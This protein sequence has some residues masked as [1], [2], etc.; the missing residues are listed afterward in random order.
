MSVA[1]V[2]VGQVV[3][4]W[5][6]EQVLSGTYARCRCACGTERRCQISNLL[7]AA[8]HGSRSCGSPVC[9]RL[10]QRAR[11]HGVGYDDYRYRLWRSIKKR[12][13]SVSSQ[14][15]SYYGGRGIRMHES[16]V[17][18]FAEFAADLVA[19]LGERPD[20]MTLDRIDNEGPYAPGNLRWATMAEQS[21]N[22]RPRC[23]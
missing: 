22:R 17:G 7:A 19:E 2:A 3:G 13:L 9:S 15:Y 8:P 20:G 16:W 21:R 11:T 12:C 14:D 1:R 5:T 6:V 4:R 10:R 18:D 23:R